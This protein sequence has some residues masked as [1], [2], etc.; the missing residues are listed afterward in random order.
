[1]IG[2]STAA[3]TAAIRSTPSIRR[4]TAPLASAQRAEHGDDLRTVEDGGRLGLDRDDQP[5]AQPLA[6]H[7]ETSVGRAIP[8]A[9]KARNAAP[10]AGSWAGVT[11]V[12]DGAKA[13]TR[14]ST[15][16]RR[17]GVLERAA[18]EGQRNRPRSGIQSHQQVGRQLGQRA[19]R[20]VENRRRSRI[21]QPRR[22]A[23]DPREAGD[24][25]A[26]DFL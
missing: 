17:L 24:L 11:M 12:A 10:T 26:R 3:R 1:M 2:A 25:R 8:A 14:R 20:V 22:V 7:A 21:A 9:S 5:P 23:D 6:V 15:A 16:V 19:G 4:P 13:A 18:D